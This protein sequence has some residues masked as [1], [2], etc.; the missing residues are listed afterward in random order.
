MS[1]A[2]YHRSGEDTRYYRRTTVEEEKKTSDMGDRI[3]RPSGDPSNPAVSKQEEASTPEPMETESRSSPDQER[4]DRGCVGEKIEADRPMESRTSPGGFVPI[5][6]DD[7]VMEMQGINSDDDD[8]ND[9]DSEAAQAVDDIAM[10]PIPYDRE[11]PATLLDLPDDI[12]ALP[13]SACDPHDNP[14]LS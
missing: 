4:I 12:L 6:E 2:K 9:E 14:V 11:D 10:S 8:D 13:I 3:I 1:P 5:K 7:A